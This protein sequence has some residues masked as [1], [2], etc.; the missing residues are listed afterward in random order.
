LVLWLNG[1]LT[2]FEEWLCPD[3]PLIQ[4]LRLGCHSLR[5]HSMSIG[6]VDALYH[7]AIL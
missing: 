5:A 7:L 4:L 6:S 2:I 1:F 3:V